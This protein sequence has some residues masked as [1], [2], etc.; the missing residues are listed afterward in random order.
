MHYRMSINLSQSDLCLRF[1][2]YNYVNQ[3]PVNCK[4]SSKSW[5][6][7]ILYYI[8]CLHDNFNLLRIYIN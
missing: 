6:A 8:D 4:L 3:L 7:I 1:V 5:I 2:P